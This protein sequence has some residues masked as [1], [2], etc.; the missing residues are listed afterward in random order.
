LKG[1]M[2]PGTEHL[3]ITVERL[4]APSDLYVQ[5]LSAIPMVFWS[6]IHPL[7]SWSPT[8]Q[9]GTALGDGTFREIIKTKSIKWV[10]VNRLWFH[11]TAVHRH[12]Q[13][14][15]GKADGHLQ[16]GEGLSRNQRRQ[17]HLDVTC[18][19]SRTVRNPYGCLHY[20]LWYAVI[21][22]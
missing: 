10:L 4:T 17:P 15:P 11:M 22:N 8:P 12:T 1:V 18:S 2:S 21:N 3:R 16:D 20:S 9:N 14:S 7:G 19:A 5:F 13:D 6:K